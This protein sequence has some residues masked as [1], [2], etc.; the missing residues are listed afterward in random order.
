[1][2]DNNKRDRVSKEDIGVKMDVVL[3]VQKVNENYT[4]LF[5]YNCYRPAEA[6][7]RKVKGVDMG[8]RSKMIDQRRHGYE[9]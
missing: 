5:G 3:I 6:S 8:I 2:Y 9:G 1:M 4:R 7:G